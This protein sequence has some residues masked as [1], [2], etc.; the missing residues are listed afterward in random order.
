LPD[1]CLL[2][3]RSRDACPLRF[4]GEPRTMSRLPESYPDAPGFKASGPS[5]QVA[6]AISSTAK[7]L[8]D[9]VREVIAMS[10]SGVT[11]DDVAFKLN[12]SILSVRPRVSELR[13]LGDIR[14]AE[15]RGKNQSGMSASRWV[16]APPLQPESPRPDHSAVRT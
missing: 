4:W 7:T 15:G 11:A 1:A 10:P 8:R 6:T 2:Q 14:Q 13:R 3:G 12:R 16:I 5:E 9:Q